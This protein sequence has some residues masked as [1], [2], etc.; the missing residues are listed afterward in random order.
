MKKN[1][2]RIIV[3]TLIC[4]LL[5]PAAG[6][7]AEAGGEAAVIS[8]TEEVIYG[9][10]DA[11]G[12]VKS[13]HSVVALNVESGGS[14]RHFGRYTGVRNLT[15]AEKI[16]YENGCVDARAEAG[17]FYYQGEMLGY[18]LPWTV[19][20][21]YKLNGEDVTAG[22]LAGSTGTVEIGIAT[23][24]N[25]AAS[26]PGFF[27]HYL[28]QITVTLDTELCSNI[29]AEGATLANAGADKQITFTALPGSQSANW[30]SCDARDFKMGGV[31]VAA[32]P[33]D[34]KSALGD[35]SQLTDGLGQLAGGASQLAGG[36]SQ[37][38]GGL[39]TYGQ[40]LN[41]ISAN[42]ASLVDGSAQIYDGLGQLSANVGQL[43]VLA[44][45][46]PEITQLIDGVNAL[47]SNYANFH[48]GLQQYTGGVDQL[49]G[50]W[51]SIESGA[52]QLAGGAGSLAGATA[53]IPS[54]VEG[55]LGGGEEFVMTS[56]LSEQNV[57]VAQVQFV[58]KTDGVAPE[59]VEAEDDAGAD[60]GTFFSRVRDLFDGI[61]YFFKGEKEQ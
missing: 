16:E 56:F 19:A 10:L 49:A 28:L 23:G 24:G 11:A 9:L 60:S 61:V 7:F 4:A 13:S 54:Q 25:D 17:R 20:V 27:N 52:N 26:N 59:A 51:G 18:E 58:I 45:L 8:S 15:N 37:L 2:Y 44:L 34:V 6:A 42:S 53:S 21:S 39:A 40:Y 32:V 55:M 46:N 36:A 30:I 12:N 50:N 29:A 3:F 43:A 38:A 31:T 1:L 41:Q 14:F 22:Q 5:I 48:A 33:Y 35:A 47:Y 57:N